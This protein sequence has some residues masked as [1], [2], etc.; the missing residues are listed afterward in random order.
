MGPN[1]VLGVAVEATAQEARVTISDTGHGI[2]PALLGH[3]F[4]PFFTTKKDA[5][6]G[7]GLWVSKGIAEKHNG[8]LEVVSSQGRDDHGTAFV[9]TLPRRN[10]LPMT[11]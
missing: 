9:L 10:A 5:G 8:R 4:E 1:G 6:T 11:A 2:A 3:I 7:L